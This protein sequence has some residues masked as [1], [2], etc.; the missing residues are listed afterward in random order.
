M[1]LC[2][3]SAR[4]RRTLSVGQRLGFVAVTLWVKRCSMALLED[5][6]ARP[7]VSNANVW[8]CMPWCEQIFA[9]FWQ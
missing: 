9:Y 6:C 5:L 4:T 1:K 7:R 3:P 8:N 2:T